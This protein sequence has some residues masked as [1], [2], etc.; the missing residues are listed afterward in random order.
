MRI[1]L[2]SD[3]GGWKLKEEMKV[4]LKERGEDTVDFGT[5]GEAS[6]D[7]PDFVARAAEAVASGECERA[8][9]VCTTGLGANIVANKVPGVRAVPCYQEEAARLSRQDNDANVLVLGQRFTPG[10]RAR[11][12]VKVWLETEFG[13][14]RHA[15]R[16]GKI[17]ELEEKYRQQ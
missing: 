5:D 9:V 8:V 7:Y 17:K 10:D 2:A 11:A 3:H 6:C 16:V 1:A 4:Y 14:G 12:I 13:G 15:R